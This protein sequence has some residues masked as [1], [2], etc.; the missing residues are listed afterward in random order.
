MTENKNK[1][2]FPILD[3]LDIRLKK[4]VNHIFLR[5]FSSWRKIILKVEF[6]IKIFR[7]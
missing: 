3:F 7:L 2:K 6:A 4:L 1:S 5:F